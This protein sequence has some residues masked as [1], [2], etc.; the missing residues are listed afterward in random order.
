M[1]KEEFKAT[2]FKIGDSPLV[3][4]RSSS[5]AVTRMRIH[6]DDIQETKDDIMLISSKT[7]FPVSQISSIQS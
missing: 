3:A 4:F 7:S 5:G 1:T 6:I 2:G